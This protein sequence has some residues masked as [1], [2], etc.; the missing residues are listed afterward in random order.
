MTYST[1]Q[2]LFDIVNSEF[3]FT[4]DACADETNHKCERYF[5]IDDNGLIQDWSGET[6]WINPPYGRDQKSWIIKAH[7]EFVAHDVTSVLLI[8]ARV[9][10]AIFHDVIFPYASQIRFIRGRLKFSGHQNSAP[11]PSC[12]VIFDKT[13]GYKNRFEWVTFRN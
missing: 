9:D 10:T 5:S 1:P 6:V 11:F 7:E 2:W 13:K 4:L 8:P 12:L 3:N